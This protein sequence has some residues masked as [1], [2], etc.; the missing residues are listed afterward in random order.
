MLQIKEKEKK[1]LWVED[2]KAERENKILFRNLTFDLDAGS[3]LHILGPNGSGKSTLLKILVGLLPAA[4]GSIYWRRGK[5][6][7]ALVEIEEK[8]RVHFPDYEYFRDILY[9]G[10]KTGVQT[11]LTAFENLKYWLEILSYE[12]YINE[13]YIKEPNGIEKALD[14]WNLTG[15]SKITCDRFSAGQCQRLALA[16]LKLIMPLKLWVLDEPCNA[17]D[18][19]GILLFEALLKN[20]LA[21][22]GSA[23]IVSHLPLNV[24]RKFSLEVSAGPNFNVL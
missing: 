17:L 21:K 15:L 24:E 23:I 5:L 3:W 19:D 8:K 7:A 22:G 2:L 4:A 14:Y 16:R 11:H 9:L 1:L 18:A 12:N 20:H 10:H 6:D 13:I